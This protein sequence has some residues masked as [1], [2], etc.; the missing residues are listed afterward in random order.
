M[1]SNTSTKFDWHTFRRRLSSLVYIFILF[2]IFLLFILELKHYFKINIFQ[3][4]NGTFDDY[5]FK[6]KD[7]LF[8]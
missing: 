2:T 4:I 3:N 7:K 1:K 5:Y 6:L 8:N